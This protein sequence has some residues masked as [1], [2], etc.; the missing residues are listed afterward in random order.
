MLL[1]HG[2]QAGHLAGRAGKL[3]RR[4]TP[5]VVAVTMAF[6]LGDIAGYCGEVVFSNPWC[7]LTSI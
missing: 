4:I 3:G 1:L 5:T 6:F 7:R 2:L